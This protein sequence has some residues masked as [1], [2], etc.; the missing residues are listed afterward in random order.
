MIHILLNYDDDCQTFID[1][2]KKELGEYSEYMEVLIAPMRRFKENEVPSIY[3]GKNFAAYFVSEP[4]PPLPKELDGFTAADN[5]LTQ[6]GIG[7]LF[8]ISA[9]HSDDAKFIITDMVGDM[10]KAFFNAQDYEPD[11]DPDGRPIRYDIP[12][13]NLLFLNVWDRRSSLLKSNLVSGM[14]NN[15]LGYTGVRYKPLKFYK[16]NDNDEKFYIDLYCG[17]N[18]RQITVLP[19]DDLECISVELVFY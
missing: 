6:S 17:H 2:F 10:T 7:L 12:F 18:H 15:Y 1:K 4:L 13:N 16:I 3:E 19:Y 11:I 9:K 14:M 5:H 8:Y